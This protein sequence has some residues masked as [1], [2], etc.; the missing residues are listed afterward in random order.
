MRSTIHLKLAA[1]EYGEAPDPYA[2]WKR[3]DV[4]ARL[5]RLAS[6]VPGGVVAGRRIEEAEASASESESKGTPDDNTVAIV[7]LWLSRVES[8][9]SGTNWPSRDR[10]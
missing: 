6:K 5:A 4:E 1:L 3:K 9:V 8:S 10:D 2:P 7:T